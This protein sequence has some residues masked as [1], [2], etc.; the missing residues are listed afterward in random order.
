MVKWVVFTV[1]LLTGCGAMPLPTIMPI[2]PITNI[3]D[4]AETITNVTNTDYLAWLVAIIGWMAPTP[5]N[6]WKEFKACVKG[7]FDYI[8]KRGN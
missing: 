3:G 2:V 7:V 5:S 8:F 6:I 4:E 1:L